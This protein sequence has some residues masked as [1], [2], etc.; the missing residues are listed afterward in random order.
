LATI[1]LSSMRPLRK[2]TSMRSAM[3]SAGRSSST[4]ST[5]MSGYSAWKSASSGATIL[6]PKPTV[7][8]MRRLPRGVPLRSSRISSTDCMDAVHARAAVLEEQLALG[9]ER[10]AARGAQEQPGV[11]LGLELLHAAAHRRASDA[12]AFGGAREAAFVD[13]GDEGDHARIGGGEA[14]SEGVAAVGDSAGA[15]G[16]LPI[17][18]P[19]PKVIEAVRHGVSFESIRRFEMVVPRRC[20]RQ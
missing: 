6:R 4:R 10:G 8:E 18:P 17:A 15:T 16:M 3:K 1:W 5:P 19:P 2:A 14:G 11:E 12:E 20:G 9:R 7:A 13:H